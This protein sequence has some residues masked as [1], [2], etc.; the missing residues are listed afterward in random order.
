MREE[1]GDAEGADYDVDFGVGEGGDEEGEG[2]GGVVC[3]D[4]FEA[5]GGECGERGVGR[6]LWSP[7]KCVNVMQ[8]RGFVV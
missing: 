4:D 7:F 3:F 1:G 5:L 6:T 2:G 8:W